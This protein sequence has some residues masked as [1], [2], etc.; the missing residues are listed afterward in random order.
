MKELA[1]KNKR[2]SQPFP[3]TALLPASKPNPCQPK[4]QPNIVHFSQYAHPRREDPVRRDELKEN[5]LRENEQQASTRG[6]PNVL[7]KDQ[8]RSHQSTQEDPM[9]RTQKK[10]RPQKGRTEW[11]A[12]EEAEGLGCH[13]NLNAQLF[14]PGLGLSRS[15]VSTRHLGTSEVTKPRR[16]RHQEDGR[17]RDDGR[18]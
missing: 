16:D 4:P 14:R 12:V 7:L 11:V 8:R 18:V 1:G 10:L 2:P 6:K 5:R 9:R 15:A 17:T 3:R 13:E